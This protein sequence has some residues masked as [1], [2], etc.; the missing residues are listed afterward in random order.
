IMVEVERHETYPHASARV[1]PRFTKDVVEG[2][3]EVERYAA[4]LGMQ[5][6]TALA[7]FGHRAVVDPAG[8]E[9]ETWLALRAALDAG[10][11]VF[12]VAALE[13]RE[14]AAVWMV[15]R[16]IEVSG[17]IPAHLSSAGNWLTSLWL[18]IVA[19][20]RGVLDSLAG[21]PVDVLRA[22]PAPEYVF[23]TV[24]LFQAF[25]RR[26][27]GLGEALS[28]ALR[29]SDP[30][31]VTD[32][33]EREVANLLRFPVLALF[34]HLT[35]PDSEAAFNAALV[36][37]LNA[38]KAYW[39][40]TEERRASAEGY[41]ALGPLALATIAQDMGITI[42]VTSDYLPASILDGTTEA[43]NG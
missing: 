29:N 23:D 20:D 5:F 27:D 9:R 42:T 41:V 15:D 35:K 8:A 39:S 13:G 17:P 24:R 34:H 38:H 7:L 32:P 37:A 25:L 31:V 6:S 22:D 40:R 19:R 3:A 26:S 21:F 1:L 2:V 36:D 28:D 30:E 43:E 11:A 14:S 12:T 10:A 33:D 18:A 4:M 16:Q